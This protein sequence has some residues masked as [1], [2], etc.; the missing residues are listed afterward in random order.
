MGVWKST[1][2]TKR[3]LKLC[4]VILATPALLCIPCGLA[5]G[6]GSCTGKNQAIPTT[7]TQGLH[8]LIT[9]ISLISAVLALQNCGHS[10]VA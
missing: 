10:K 1:V 5:E 2:I 4:Q 6:Q 9:L 8:T 3:T 7:E